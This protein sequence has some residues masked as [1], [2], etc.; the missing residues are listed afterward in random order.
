[1]PGSGNPS[2]WLRDLFIFE[3]LSAILNE[4]GLKLFQNPTG[5]DI[6]ESNTISKTD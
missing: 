3:H 4:F 1:M 2:V 6:L 5:Y